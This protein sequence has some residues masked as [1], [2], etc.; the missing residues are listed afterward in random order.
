MQEKSKSEVVFVSPL[1]VIGKRL[2]VPSRLSKRHQNQWPSKSRP[3]REQMLPPVMR[4]PFVIRAV[5]IENNL[6]REENIISNW[7]FSLVEDPM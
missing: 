3:K 5:D 1:N 7:V 6:I 4:S 2:N